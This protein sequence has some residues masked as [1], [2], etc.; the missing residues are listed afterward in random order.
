MVRPPATLRPAPAPPPAPAT[1]GSAQPEPAAMRA[2]L[3]LIGFGHVGRRFA[4]LLIEHRERLLA[5]HDIDSRVVSIATRRHGGA[6]Q[7]DGIDLRSA[8]DAAG[9][10]AIAV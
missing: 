7:P 9:R 4:E 10:G 1:G 5:E 3:A 2:D 6:T 8:L